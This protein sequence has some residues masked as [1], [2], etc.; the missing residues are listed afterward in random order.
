[1]SCLH[2]AIPICNPFCLLVTTFNKWRMQFECDHNTLLWLRCDVSKDDKT[3]VEM[4]WCEACRKHEDRITGIKNLSKVWITGSNNQ[5]TSNIVDHATSEQHCAAMVRVR[6]NAARASK[7]PLTTYSPIAR[8][9]LVM[10]EAVQGR[11]KR[12]FDI[13]YVM[14]KESLGFRKYPALHELEERHGV[15]LSFAYKTDVSAQ[16]FTHYIAESQRQS[17]LESFSILNFYSFPHG[18]IH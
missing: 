5:K 13:C 14:A 7:Q 10:D 9:L 11:M 12:K 8:S 2:I 16:T 18:W 17:F 15:D 6:A 1:M 3:V 4:L